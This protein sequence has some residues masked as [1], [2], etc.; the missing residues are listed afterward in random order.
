MTFPGLDLGI[1]HGR[2]QYTA[3]RGVNLLRQE[4]IA[5]TDEPSVAYKYVA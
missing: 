5:E 3:Y 1:F 4:A 2:L